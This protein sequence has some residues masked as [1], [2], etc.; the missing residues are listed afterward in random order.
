MAKLIDAD[1][2]FPYGS[3]PFYQD[4][5]F[6][7]ADRIYGIIKKAPTVDA[8]E[9]VHGR[10]VGYEGFTTVGLDKFGREIDKHYRYF[11]CDKCYKKNVVRSN[12]CPNCGA[13]MDGDGNG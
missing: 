12:Y 9:V 11:Q 2:L 4:D 7:T 8:V 1:K 3:V 6:R 5:G 13:K 10:W